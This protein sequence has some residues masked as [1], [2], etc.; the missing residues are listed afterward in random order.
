MIGIIWNFPDGRS[1]H[2][3]QPNDSRAETGVTELAG[4]H[5]SV[6]P[7]SLHYSGHGLACIPFVAEFRANLENE[8]P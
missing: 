7:E 6:N 4:E 2:D 3:G 5:I 8:A 1:P